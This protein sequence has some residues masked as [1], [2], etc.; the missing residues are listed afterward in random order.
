MASS[1]LLLSA[2]L[3][4]LLSPLLASPASAQAT[5]VQATPTPEPVAQAAPASETTPANDPA[6][7]F[8]A[9]ILNLFPSD[10]TSRFG[11]VQAFA[12]SV[13]GYGVRYFPLPFKVDVRLTYISHPLYQEYALSARYADTTFAVGRFENGDGGAKLGI[14]HVEVTH[15]PYT[16]LQYGAIY[17]DQGRSSRLNLG[18]AVAAGPSR[19]YGELGYAFQGTVDAPYLHFEAST[20][21]SRTDGPFTVG[22]YGT[23]RSYVFPQAA[24]LS[25]DFSASVT[26]RPTDYSSVTI[27]Q[28]ERFVV[29]S[30]TIPDLAVG[31]YTRSNLDIVL[32]PNAKAGPFSL[33]NLEYHYQYSFL[34]GDSS[35]NAVGFTVRADV[36]PAFV[37]DL[38]PHHDFIANETGLRADLFYRGVDL[39]ILVGPS[40]DYILTPTGSRYVITLKAGVK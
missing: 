33:R 21:G 25:T 4:L 39:P 19:F 35:V 10:Y 28:F 7:S 26:Y 27:S 11:N 34:G 15:N 9:Q 31:R 5:S 37:I 16:G 32:N 2:A 12:D 6:L 24:Q 30:S 29:G 22:A 8:T 18:Y 14:A 23:F 40:F 3:T 17:Q 38:T 1:P 13:N 20:G 36:A